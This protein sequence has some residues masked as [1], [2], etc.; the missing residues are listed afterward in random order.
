MNVFRDY[1]IKWWQLSLLKVCMIALGLALG[2]TW[3]GVV[4]PWTTLL[5]IVFVVPAAYLTFAFA[6]E[7][8]GKGGS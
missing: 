4:A 6:P 2:A 5:W 1:T 3:P 7:T 8:W